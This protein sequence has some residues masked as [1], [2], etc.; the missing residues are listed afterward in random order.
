MVD[1]TWFRTGEGEMFIKKPVSTQARE[2]AE[3]MRDLPE[4][5]VDMLHGVATGLKIAVILTKH[6]PPPPT[7]ES[8][9][10]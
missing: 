6:A 1:E 2:I 3:T 5:Y 8:I 7:A 9:P 10:A 4:N